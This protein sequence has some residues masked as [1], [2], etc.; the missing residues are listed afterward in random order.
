[1]R[2]LCPV[3]GGMQE[4]R[5]LPMCLSCFAS[6]PDDLRRQAMHRSGIPAAIE[7]ARKARIAPTPEQEV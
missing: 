3:C 4:A 6:L 1:M 7:Y 2:P 5:S